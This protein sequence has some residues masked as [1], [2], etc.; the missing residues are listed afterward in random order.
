M[1][2]LLLSSVYLIR[3]GI[4]PTARVG[5]ILLPILV[6]PIVA[7][8]ITV[9]PE[10]D[11]TNLL[12]I[13]INPPQKMLLGAAIT[14]YSFLGFE[15][16]LIL[17]PYIRSPERVRWILFASIG[18]VVVLSFFITVV[19]FIATGV[20]DAQLMMWPS[21]TVIRSIAAP[22]RSFERLD[23]LALALWIIAAF[24]TINGAYIAASITMAHWTKSREF[25]AFITMLF[26][27]IY[28]VAIYPENALEIKSLG[29]FVGAMGLIV[30]ILFPSLV[31]LVD[32]IKGKGASG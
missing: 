26:P 14:I 32:A 10:A 30:A 12:P 4:E 15:I 1:I 29:P 27:W 7:M 17:G 25:K 28:L 11:F 13:F 18:T 24:T 3:H 20:E 23:A 8:Y 31:L 5:E 19:V 22:G 16:L 2:T 9:L 6:V 21:M